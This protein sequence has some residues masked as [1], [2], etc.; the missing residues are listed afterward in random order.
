MPACWQQRGLCTYVDHRVVVAPPQGMQHRRLIEV[1]QRRHVFHHFKLWMIHLLNFVLLDT[2]MLQRAE[3]YNIYPPTAS[4]C[5]HFCQAL[6]RVFEE[7]RKR[8]LIRGGAKGS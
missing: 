2:Q 1:S 3:K 6:E 5:I 7:L 8:C 4:V